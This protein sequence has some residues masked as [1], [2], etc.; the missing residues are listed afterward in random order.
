MSITSKV[1]RLPSGIS[2]REGKVR[3]QT[4]NIFGHKRQHRQID[5]LANKL[6]YLYGTRTIAIENNVYAQSFYIFECSISQV[7]LFQIYF[8]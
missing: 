6:F 8:P 5:G 7:I 1:T 3:G 4:K 2:Q